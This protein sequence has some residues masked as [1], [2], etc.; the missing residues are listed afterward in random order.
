M[1]IAYTDAPRAYTL[2]VGINVFG[3]TI[4]EVHPFVSCGLYG[5]HDLKVLPQMFLAGFNHFKGEENN[6]PR[7]NE[8]AAVAT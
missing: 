4:I 6:E 2:D 5:F 1:I 8:Q 3:T 7:G